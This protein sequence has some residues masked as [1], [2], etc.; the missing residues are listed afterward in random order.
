[1]FLFEA[2]VNLGPLRSK[3]S[4]GFDNLCLDKFIVLGD[5]VLFEAF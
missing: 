4:S 2:G 5:M 1:M 3:L